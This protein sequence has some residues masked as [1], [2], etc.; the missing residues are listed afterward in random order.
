MAAIEPKEI[1]RETVRTMMRRGAQLLE[2]LPKEEYERVHL[3]GAA[4]IPLSRIDRTTADKLKWDRPVIVYSHSFLDDLSARA[5]WR[6]ANLGFTQVFRYSGGKADWLANGLPAE[7]SAARAA[8]AGDLADMD[9]PTCKP[10]ER[11]NAI[12]ERVRKEGWNICV[13]VN[14]QVIALGLL[15][16]NAF[17]KADPNWTA[18]EA[19]ERDPLTYRL[20]EPVNQVADSLRNHYVDS[21]LVTTT[22]S[23]L[24]GLIKLDDIEKLLRTESQEKNR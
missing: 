18:E 7:G 21:G 2:V 6:L 9:V 5:A 14:E 16:S 10:S 20:N 11:I 24:F 4:N 22:D 17:D 8:G 19:M 23:K 12:R 15:R 1:N 13:V 3:A